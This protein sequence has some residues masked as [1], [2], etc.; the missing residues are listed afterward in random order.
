M[1]KWIEFVKAFSE[2]NNLS[3]KDAMSSE[4]CKKE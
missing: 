3:Y 4:K 1:T 2:K